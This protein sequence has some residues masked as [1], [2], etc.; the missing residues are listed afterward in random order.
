MAELTLKRVQELAEG[1]IDFEGQKLNESLATSL[2]VVAGVVSFLYGY[3]RQDIIQTLYI[4]LGGTALTFFLVV[5][6]W[7][8]YRSHPVKWLPVEG[9]D[10]HVR[11]FL[12]DG[13]VII[14][15]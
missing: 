4:G 13:M 6:P 3:F 11:D 2:L 9:S 12:P 10:K 15:K 5:P 8:F 1:Q 14:S 7:P